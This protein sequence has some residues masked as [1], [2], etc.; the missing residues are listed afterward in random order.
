LQ[1]Y[2]GARRIA[3]SDDFNQSAPIA[4]GT[5]YADF[6]GKCADEGAEPDTL[7][8]AANQPAL[9]EGGGL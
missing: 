2:I 1:E 8:A 9:C 3:C 5:V 6:A 4:H 7:N